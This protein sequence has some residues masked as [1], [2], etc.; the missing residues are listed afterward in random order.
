MCTPHTFVLLLSVLITGC[1]WDGK[2]IPQIAGS[3][4]YA[5]G[6]QANGVRVGAAALSTLQGKPTGPPVIQY[7]I[8]NGG[9]EP[10]RYAEPACIILRGV[11]W[12]TGHIDVTGPDGQ[13]LRAVG[14][15]P[16]PRKG[17]DIRPGQVYEG[18]LDLAEYFHFKQPGKYRV[19]LTLTLFPGSDRPGDFAFPG[20]A[21]VK[22]SMTLAESDARAEAK[23][24]KSHTQ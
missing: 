21:T 22:F 24:K 10:I 14:V 7:V 23:P 12:F 1:S 11:A 8:W 19:V 2:D 17:G 13:R 4:R 5:W 15:G 18:H 3:K 20:S 9:K 6:K 16:S